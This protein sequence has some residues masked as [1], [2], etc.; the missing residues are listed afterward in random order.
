MAEKQRGAMPASHGCSK[1]SVH[2]EDSSLPMRNCEKGRRAHQ[3]HPNPLNHNSMDLQKTPQG[4]N[5]S[6]LA[7]YSI[8]LY[9]NDVQC[10]ERQ[11]HE[12]VQSR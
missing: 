6:E 3:I 12:P 7:R 1:N 11:C 2:C 5:E 4:S 9:F 10:I 8:L